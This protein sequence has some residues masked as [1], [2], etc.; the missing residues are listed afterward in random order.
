VRFALSLRDGPD[1]MLS[2][3]G[4][5]LQIALNGVDGTTAAELECFVEL[6]ETAR[7]PGPRPR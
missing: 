1:L 6:M 2:V 4:L 7:R 3:F 5:Q